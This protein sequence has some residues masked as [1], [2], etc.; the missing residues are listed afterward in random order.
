MFGPCRWSPRRERRWGPRRRIEW[1][2]DPRMKRNGVLWAVSFIEVTR[3]DRD[4]TLPLNPAGAELGPTLLILPVSA[5]RS[6]AIHQPHGFPRPAPGRRK[7]PE[8]KTLVPCPSQAPS[9][10][11]SHA[12]RWSPSRPTAPRIP[13]SRI[14]PHGVVLSPLVSLRWPIPRSPG[15]KPITSN[16]RFRFQ[17]VDRHPRSFGTIRSSSFPRF[18]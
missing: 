2:G 15:V 8:T 11:L 5:C 16:G 1:F 13:H 12:S 10:N 14:G 17:D 4:S 9:E 7:P 3:E 18:Q 6:Q